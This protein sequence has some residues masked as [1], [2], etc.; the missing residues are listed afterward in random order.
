MRSPYFSDR[1]TASQPS[2]PS[3]FNCS[4]AKTSSSFLTCFA[5]LS[6]T[7]RYSN[8]VAGA[9]GASIIGVI[10]MDTSFRHPRSHSAWVPASV[11]TRTSG[12]RG[13]TRPEPLDLLALDDECGQAGRGP[14]LVLFALRPEHGLAGCDRLCDAV[15]SAHLARP[16]EHGEDLRKRRR[17]P[18][19]SAPGGHAEDRRL[20]RRPLEDGRSEPRHGDA[21]EQVPSRHEG[22]L[23]GEGEPFQRQSGLDLNENVRLHGERPAERALLSD[24]QHQRGGDG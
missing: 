4:G 21:F 8:R 1:P 22:D 18:G 6:G 12:S 7:T 23:G 17:M 14:R 15:L 3:S 9:A 11:K 13:R 19:E 20:Y 2:S 5:S 24:D 16:L 10:A